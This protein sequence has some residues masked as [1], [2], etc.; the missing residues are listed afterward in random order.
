MDASAHLDNRLD[1]SISKNFINYASELEK[2]GYHGMSRV[3]ALAVHQLCLLDAG[4]QIGYAIW[5]IPK[6]S[7]IACGKLM[8][9]QSAQQSHDTLSKQAWHVVRALAFI[10]AAAGDFAAIPLLLWKPAYIH[11][12]HDRLSLNT[13]W[14]KVET[15]AGWKQRLC[16]IPSQIKQQTQQMTANAKKYVQMVPC[17]PTLTKSLVA[18]G[19]TSLAGI[20]AYLFLSGGQTSADLNTVQGEDSKL[21]E[22]SRFEAD[23]PS[24]VDS[25]S[26]MDSSFQEEVESKSF[27]SSSPSLTIS[28]PSQPPI[29]SNSTAS[30]PVAIK[31]DLPSSD[32][33]D[34][35]K[36]V[37]KAAGVLGAGT[38]L[39]WKGAAFIKSSLKPGQKLN[40][41]TY[42]LPNDTP[43]EFL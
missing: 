36:G 25:P 14:E 34:T 17:N 30:L 39:V 43:V 22:I 6:A 41:N 21:P 40:A 18:V 3:S 42:V 24:L 29:V 4:I 10:G 23:S 26:L 35:V 19:L 5:A 15:V 20:G 13:P 12:I 11:S 16:A 8:G 32:L 27:I 37:V 38:L 28:T 31:E 9:I 33:F 7:F 2:A 1:V